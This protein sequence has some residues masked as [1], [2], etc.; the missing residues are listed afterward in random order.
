MLFGL[1][2]FLLVGLE[3][4][5][6]GWLPSYA[7]LTGAMKKEEATICGSLFWGMGT[8]LR[9]LTAASTIKCSYKLKTCLVLIVLS[10][11]VCLCLHLL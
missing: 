7:V 10:S 5:S 4:T 2:F 6:S 9:F 8:L 1:G 3:F 11:I